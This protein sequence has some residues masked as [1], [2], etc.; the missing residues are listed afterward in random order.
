MDEN[1]LA[2]LK[3]SEFIDLLGSNAPAP[4]GG[5]AA[6]LSAAMGA[7]LTNMVCALTTGKKKYAEHE[8]LVREI[9]DEIKTIT[10]HLQENIDRDTE[11]YNGVSAVFAMPKDT[12]EEKAARSQ[13][14]QNALKHA[15]LVPFE[16]MGL[17]HDAL[18]LT[19]R[20]VGHSNP[21]A[22]SDLGVAALTLCAGL[23]GAWFNVLINL[24][25]IKDRDFVNRYKGQG[26]AVVEAAEEI[27]DYITTEITSYVLQ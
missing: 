26:Q 11:A 21:N 12:D 17:C 10:A 22:A 3:I 18:I 15:A 9:S 14:M 27:A 16:V 23:K 19:K 7:A 25:G 24:S 1:K 8:A 2:E 4:G 20:A 13:A 6:A 5:S